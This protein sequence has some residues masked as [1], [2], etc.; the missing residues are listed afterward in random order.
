MFTLYELV[1][2]NALQVCLYVKKK[3]G[4]ESDWTIRWD[5]EVFDMRLSSHSWST[6]FLS[7]WLNREQSLTLICVAFLQYF[8]LC[9]A[10]LQL[11]R[12]IVRSIR[13]V[14]QHLS[15]YHICSF[16]FDLSWGFCKYA[17]QTRR[18][19]D[20]PPFDLHFGKCLRF[21]WGQG[22][23]KVKWAIVACLFW[24][25]LIE[26]G[27]RQLYG[28][29]NCYHPIWIKSDELTDRLFRTAPGVVLWKY[30]TATALSVLLWLP[31][32]EKQQRCAKLQNRLESMSSSE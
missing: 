18:A 10:V 6:N 15:T 32:I 30:P 28:F 12:N 16:V 1:S 29:F 17:P 3:Q 7:P 9:N 4:K 22:N 20:S 14:K 25:L 5:R 23:V 19:H 21:V 11:L 2:F 27:A 8:I 24:F 31:F 26:L 13:L